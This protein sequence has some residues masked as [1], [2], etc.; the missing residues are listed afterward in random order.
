MPEITAGLVSTIVPFFNRGKMLREAVASVLAQ[1]YRPIEVIVSDDGST[2][3]AGQVA[4][5]LGTEN[6]G[7]VRVIRSSVNRGA[8]PAREAG[9][10]AAKGEFIQYLDSDDLLAPRK[11][12]LQVEALRQ[13]PECGA[14]YGYV[15]LIECDGRELPQPYKGSGEAIPHL[16]PRLLVERWWSTN[17]PLYRRTLCDAVGPWSALRYSQ[18]W[19]YDARVGALK[20]RL[21]HV[22]DYVCIQ[23]QHGGPRQTGHGGWLEPPERVRFFTSLLQCARKAGVAVGIPEMDF[24][25]RWVFL[26]ARQCGAQGDAR[27]AR[28]LY[29]IACG[30]V[31]RRNVR[32]RATGLLARCVGW[33]LVG[34]MAAVRDSLHFRAASRAA[35][36]DGSAAGMPVDCSRSTSRGKDRG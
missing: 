36:R 30:S 21:A 24:F 12:E 7:V 6:P 15:R 13:H 4:D 1:T 3:G 16:F 17:C 28:V 35:H 26:N 23:R 11:F 25:S 20:T 10:L 32:L 29:E 5:A 34:R 27:A 18:D 8:G 14:A 33:K 31:R 19:E 2:D 9:R 22:P